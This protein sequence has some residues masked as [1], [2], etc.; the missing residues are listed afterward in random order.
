[1]VWSVIDRWPTHPG[2]VKAFAQVI[3][4]ELAKFPDEVR[5]DVVILFSAHSLP[6]KVVNRGDPY[7]AEVAATVSSVMAE[8]GHTHPYR[9]VWQSKV[10]PLPWLG[11]QTDEV[12]EGLVKRGKKNLLLVPIAFTSDHIETLFELDIE[13]ATELANK[14][15]VENIR[16]AAAMNS[17]KIFIQGLADIVKAHLDDGKVSSTQLSLRCPLCVNS[18]CAQ[19]RQFIQGQQSALDRLRSSAV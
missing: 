11:P 5:D 7:A 17:N 3:E 8:L 9:L 13:Y 14:V 1:M 12:I 15:G 4:E 16:R 10:G 6:M 2:L 18:T 19:T